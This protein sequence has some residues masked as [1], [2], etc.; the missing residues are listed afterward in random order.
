MKDEALNM[1]YN[2][3]FYRAREA[4]LREKVA[5][6]IARSLVENRTDAIQS[7]RHI[8]NCLEDFGITEQLLE[9]LYSDAKEVAEIIEAM[10]QERRELDGIVNQRGE[11]K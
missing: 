2:Q 8:A 7:L 6:G 1:T 3:D 10:I 9:K 11:L 4:R 5:L